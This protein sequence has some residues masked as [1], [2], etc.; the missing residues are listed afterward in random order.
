MGDASFFTS[1]DGD[2]FQPTDACRG[3]WDPKA[4]HAGP[5]TGLL[6]RASEQAVPQQPLVRIT[7]DLVRAIPHAGFRLTADV[8]R[9]GRTVST[10]LL[11]LIDGDGKE[12]VTARGL[13]QA[14]VEP[15]ALGDVPTTPYTPPP[16]AAAVVEPF[17]VREAAHGLPFFSSG[18]ETRYNPGEPRGPGPKRVWMRALP[19]LDDEEPSPF[20]RICPLADCVNAFGR[21]TDDVGWAFMN[22]DLT[23]VIHRPPEGEWFGIDA[24]GR[25]EPNGI[26]VSDGVLFDQVGAVGKATQT[27]LIRRR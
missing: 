3:P 2:W 9:A 5:P 17:P 11:R 23:V 20:Q 25:W 27:L 8:S 1:P 16:F 13:H 26:G 15:G 12:V 22:T 6:A 10:T 7:V 21:P 24:V 19:L 4:C 14:T 18:V